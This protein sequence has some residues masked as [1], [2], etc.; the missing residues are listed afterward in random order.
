MKTHSLC[1]CVPLLQYLQQGLFSLSKI[2]VTRRNT[3]HWSLQVPYPTV[4]WYKESHCMNMNLTPFSHLC[5]VFPQLYIKRH[6]T[7]KTT[8]LDP[9]LISCL[10]APTQATSWVMFSASQSYSHTIHNILCLSECVWVKSKPFMTIVT[11][12][13][14]H[15][16][17][18]GG[19]NFNVTDVSTT[20]INT[21]I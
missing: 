4:T 9:D 19:V 17:T 6:S 15:L 5:S 12:I 3:L 18:A 21:Q 10:I 20:R 7:R 11:Q 13:T 16:F 2:T 8:S 14:L 1:I